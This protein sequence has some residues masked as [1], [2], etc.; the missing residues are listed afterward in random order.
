MNPSDINIESEERVELLSVGVDIGSATSH[1]VFSKITVEKVGTRYVTVGRDALYESPI[2]LTPYDGP[3]LIDPAA[4]SAYVDAQFAAAGLRRDEVDTGALILT[5]VALDRANSRTIGEVFAREAGKMVAVSAGD[6]MECV[7]A[8]KGSGA[9]ER[10]ETTDGDLLHIDIGGGT[11]KM[12]LCRGGKPLAHLA[13]DVG[14]RLV[15]SGDDGVV[16][17]LEEAG[18]RAGRALGIDL[19]VGARVAEVDRTRIAEY[20]VDELFGAA[21]I[22]GDGSSALLRGQPLP[23]FTPS[24]VSFSGGVSEYVYGRQEQ[25]FGDL[26]PL[27]ARAIRDRLADGDLAL[28]ENVNAGIRATVLGAS[29][30][31]VQLSGS[32]IYVSDPD[33]LP[34]RNVQ[35]VTPPFDLSDLSAQ[36]VAEALRRSLAQFDLIDTKQP[37]AVSYLWDGL[38]TYDRIDQFCHGIA[39]GIAARTQD[40]D[41]AV[42][43]VSE[44]D[45]GRLIGSHLATE[46]LDGRPVVSVDCVETT[47]F[48]FIDVGRPVTGSAS[49]PVVIK[50]LVF[51]STSG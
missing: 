46:R 37:V 34:V 8:A 45:I 29:Q 27:L 2:I 21:R 12:V 22:T 11:A 51:P 35:V 47:D 1:L 16:V 9:L 17:R 32:T 49:V 41:S 5:G 7:L 3:D 48:A 20:L 19:A 38:A 18:G 31:T 42:V 50:S 13:V 39:M 44:D 33:G 15:V 30:Y 43:L 26:G 10:S 6:N 40:T 25:T 28:V 24:A 23:E 14:A 36:G 4:L